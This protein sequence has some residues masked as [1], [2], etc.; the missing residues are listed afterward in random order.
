[1][2]SEQ[3]PK[4]QKNHLI[5][6]VG[7]SLESIVFNS[8]KDVVVLFYLPFSKDCKI[9]YP[10]FS[11]VSDKFKENTDFIFGNFNLYSNDQILFD[12]KSFPTIAIWP[13]HNKSQ[14]IISNVVYE[15]PNE[16]LKF[17]NENS[18]SKFYFDDYKFEDKNESKE[19][20]YKLE[21]ERE[22]ETEIEDRNYD[23][24]S[25]KETET[26]ESEIMNSDL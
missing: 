23:S 1:M 16:I 26:E 21:E 18:Y 8:Q 7:S 9:V 13:S 5:E 24:N 11:K 4:Y 2:K 22:K 15:D 25:S 14:P 20:D 6:I 17:I 10:I 19:E 12:L 3:P